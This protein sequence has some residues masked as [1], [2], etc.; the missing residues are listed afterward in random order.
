MS[1]Q[2]S[3][4]K[5]I[6]QQKQYFVHN[7][8]VSFMEAWRRCQVL[9]QR[10]A[11]ITSAEDSKLLEETLNISITTKGTWWIAGTDLG[12]EG[13]FVWIST[14]EPVGYRNFYKNQ[15]DNYKGREHCLEIGRYG[16]VQWN[17]APC[18]LKQQ[19]ICEKFT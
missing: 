6:C 9:G 3:V 1:L 19:F 4:S 2:F 12:S 18:D 14:N 13:S 11:T 8:S 7:T 16:G 15:P 17:D 5:S 10:L